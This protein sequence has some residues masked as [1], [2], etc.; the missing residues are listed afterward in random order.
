MMKEDEVSQA[1]TV[2]TV[3]ETSSYTGLPDSVYSNNFLIVRCLALVAV[4]VAT[5]GG[6]T[7]A[8]LTEGRTLVAVVGAAK[9][10]AA[11]ASGA[12]GSGRDWGGGLVEEGGGGGGE[13]EGRKGSCWGE[14]GVWAK[15]E[16]GER[17]GCWEPQQ[18]QVK[19]QNLVH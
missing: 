5:Q 16:L 14:R 6:D 18:E 15:E 3:M 17:Q 1:D 7:G 8:S 2:S 13:D 10:R 11:I 12:S 19:T 4:V 9:V